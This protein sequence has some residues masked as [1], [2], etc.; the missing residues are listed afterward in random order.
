MDAPT[1]PA[2]RR[3]RRAA[4]PFLA[5]WVATVTAAELLG[6]L[7]PVTIGVATAS[8]PWPVS[9]PLVLAAGAVEGTVLGAGQALVLRRALPALRVGRWIGLTALGAVL[10][11]ALAAPGTWMGAFDTLPAPTRIALTVASALALL[12]ALGGAQWV[13]LRRSVP[14]AWTW[15]L[16]VALGWLLALGA[17]L[18]IATPLWQPGQPVG[19]ALLIGV[20]AGVVMAVVQ[21]VVTGAGMRHILAVHRSGGTGTDRDADASSERAATRR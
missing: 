5:G 3:Q 10:A 12:A 9:V 19:V 1:E 17:F 15:I 21:A 18:G 16:W 8:L 11:Y 2:R 4:A 20:L 14:R 13:E 6:F 7:V